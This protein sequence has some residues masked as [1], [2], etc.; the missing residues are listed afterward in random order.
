[1]KKN[2]HLFRVLLL[3]VA[4]LFIIKS[5]FCQVIPR[6]EIP[7][8]YTWNLSN[9]YPSDEAWREAKEALHEKSSEIETFKGTLTRS[10]ADLLACLEFNSIFSKEASRLY[11]YASL[12][13]DLD[14][15]NMH[16]SGM[17]Q[18]L[19]QMFSEFGARS[20]FIQPEI[21][22]ADWSRIEGFIDEEPRL[23]PYRKGLY[24]LF[25]LEKHNL[26][27]PE[28]RIMALSGTIGGVAG[29]VYTTF[30]NAEMPSAEAILPDGSKK[31]ISFADYARMRASPSRE[32][33]IGRAHV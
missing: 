15:R 33:K 22:T 30:F 10:A 13:A 14:T 9:I 1:M 16:Y 8:K 21:L 32:E 5:S 11:L 31:E 18:E 19:S 28:E 4:G 17:T 23:E 7:A 27:E 29:S 3:L 24:N 20:A 2:R 6:N 25:R 26:S 12:N